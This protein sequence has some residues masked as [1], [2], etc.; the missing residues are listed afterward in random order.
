VITYHWRVQVGAY[1]IAQQP[2]MPRLG[3]SVYYDALTTAGRAFIDPRYLARAAGVGALAL[4]ATLHAGFM[5]LLRDR[6][7]TPVLK[8]TTLDVTR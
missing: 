7:G 1:A 8:V 5:D 6:I 4:P 2:G 3:C